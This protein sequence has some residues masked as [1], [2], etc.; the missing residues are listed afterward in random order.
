MDDL[1]DLAEGDIV[2]VTDQD[3]RV[4]YLVTD[5]E[6]WSKK[7]LAHNAVEAFGQDRHHGRLVLVTCE[8]WVDGDYR[9]NVVVFAEPVPDAA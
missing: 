5:V 4:D 9:S 3:G 1:E 8:D 2:H 7:K 6:V